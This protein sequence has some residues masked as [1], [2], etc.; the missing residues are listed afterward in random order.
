MYV[1]Y[2]KEF[3]SINY[4]L[5]P[6]VR[7]CYIAVIDSSDLNSLK[8]YSG[9]LYAFTGVSARSDSFVLF[10]FLFLLLEMVLDHH[11][12]C[13]NKDKV[14]MNVQLLNTVHIC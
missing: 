4:I 1:H 9:A 8:C 5:S 13:A 11:R 12:L 14:C 7:A 3:C 2:G 6:F 10:C